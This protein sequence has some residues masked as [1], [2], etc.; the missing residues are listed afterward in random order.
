M[1]VELEG[2][3]E[4]FFTESRRHH[5]SVNDMLTRRKDASRVQELRVKSPISAEGRINNLNIMP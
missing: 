1:R 5:R 2:V 4:I 3:Y